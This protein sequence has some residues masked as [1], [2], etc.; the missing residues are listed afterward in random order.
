MEPDCGGNEMTGIPKEQIE[1]WCRDYEALC[2]KHK[3]YLVFEDTVWLEEA[4]EPLDYE[5]AAE[6]MRLELLQ[7][8]A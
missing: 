4:G 5:E 1:G 2:A 8:K 7:H 6:N 3:L